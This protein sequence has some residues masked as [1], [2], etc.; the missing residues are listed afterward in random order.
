MYPHLE[1]SNF[2]IILS[3]ERT[4]KVVILALFIQ[5][6]QLRVLCQ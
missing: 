3:I 5:G 2:C 6:I 4:E 1:V